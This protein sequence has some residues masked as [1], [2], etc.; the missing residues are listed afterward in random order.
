MN[1]VKELQE[2]YFM[3]NSSKEHKGGIPHSPTCHCN[4]EYD[5]RKT[6]NISEVYHIPQP[7][8][9]TL[10]MILEKTKKKDVNRNPQGHIKQKC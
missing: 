5:I 1:E 3:S 8:I 2:T 4:P 9:G 7:T 10:N 6:K